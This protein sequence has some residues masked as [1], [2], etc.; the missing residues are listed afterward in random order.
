MACCITNAEQ[1]EK[2]P[3]NRLSEI[4]EVFFMKHLGVLVGMKVSWQCN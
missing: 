3:T 1:R 2:L 4:L